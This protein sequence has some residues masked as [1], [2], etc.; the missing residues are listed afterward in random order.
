MLGRCCCG[1]CCCGGSS[2]DSTGGGSSR[3]PSPVTL[4]SG[5]FR[6][7]CTWSARGGCVMRIWPYLNEILALGLGHQ[8]LEFGGGKGVHQTSLGDDEEQHLRAGEDGQ[9]VSLNDGQYASTRSTRP[10]RTFFMMPAL[11]LEKVM[12]RRDL[13]VMNLISIFLRSR[14][15]LSSSSSSSSIEG[16]WRLIPRGSLPLAWSS[17]PGGGA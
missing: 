14:P 7:A 6:H 17:R 13:S 15:A 10:S 4:G 2:G 8:W 12:W 3:P 1:I 11:R 5:A 16:R 9:L